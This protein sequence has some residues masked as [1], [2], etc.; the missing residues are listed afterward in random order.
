[1]LDYKKEFIFFL[2]VGGSPFISLIF[3]SHYSGPQSRGWGKR[4][5]KKNKIEFFIVQKSIFLYPKEL[6]NPLYLKE[7]IMI[8]QS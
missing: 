1:M 5:G 3:D 4:S 7:W 6:R 8:D 2:E